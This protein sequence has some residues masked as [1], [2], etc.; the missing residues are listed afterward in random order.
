MKSLSPY[1]AGTCFGLATNNDSYRHRSQ[2]LPD[3]SYI[4]LAGLH[5]PDTIL[6]PPAPR[7]REASTLGKVLNC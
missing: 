4:I 3:K 6:A 1:P 2:F 7:P 5:E